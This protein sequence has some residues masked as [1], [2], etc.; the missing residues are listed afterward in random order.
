M[1]FISGPVV[2]RPSETVRFQ[3]VFTAH[4]NVT[5]AKWWK[6]K[7]HDEE[8]IRLDMQKILIYSRRYETKIIH[9]F[10]ILNASEDD[11]ATY[12]LSLHNMESNKIRT[13][14]DGMCEQFILSEYCQ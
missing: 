7:T 10:E 3:T 4:Q 13:I 6:K 5:E 2:V 8:E 9:R 11:T 12:R 1:I 14:V